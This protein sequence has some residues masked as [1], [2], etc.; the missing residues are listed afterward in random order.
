MIMPQIMSALSPQLHIYVV[1]VV[2]NLSMIGMY[3]D[4]SIDHAEWSRVGK[5][6]GADLRVTADDNKQGYRPGDTPQTLI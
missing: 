4:W 3:I 1:V 6:I 5:T 2:S